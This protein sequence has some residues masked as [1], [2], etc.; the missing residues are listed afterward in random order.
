MVINFVEI[1][2]ARAPVDTSKLI[3]N[4]QVS[5]GSAINTQIDA[6]TEGRAGSTAS[7]TRAAVISRS[8]TAL[9]GKPVGQPIYVTNNVDYLED[10]DRDKGGF[11]QPSFQAAIARAE[12]T[13]LKL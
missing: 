6:I 12:A 2:T 10:Q 4:F 5:V 7:S 3:S 9:R 8:R 11:L 1:V 13:G